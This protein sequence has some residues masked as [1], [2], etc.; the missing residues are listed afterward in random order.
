[1][2][3]SFDI[4]NLEQ[5]LSL[6]HDE[7]SLD[8]ILTNLNINVNNRNKLVLVSKLKFNP[9]IIITYQKDKNTIKTFYRYK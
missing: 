7:C 9:H 4:K 8:A 5:W 2:K 3:Q 1:M 6:Q